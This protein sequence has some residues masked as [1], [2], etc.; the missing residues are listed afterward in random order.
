MG[1]PSPGYFSPPVPPPKPTGIPVTHAPHVD[2]WVCDWDD[3]FER[4]KEILSMP[5]HPHRPDYVVREITISPAYSEF[6]AKLEEARIT[7]TYRYVGEIWREPTFDEALSASETN[8][9]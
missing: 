6:N 1:F 5:S 4:A 2:V 8:P 7:V 9:S 3:R